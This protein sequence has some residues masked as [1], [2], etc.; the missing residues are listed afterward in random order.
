MIGMLSIL[1]ILLAGNS[2]VAGFFDYNLSLDLLRTLDI[3]TIIIIALMEVGLMI[4]STKIINIAKNKQKI[5]N[6]FIL[7]GLLFPIFMVSI[8]C[9]EMFGIGTA[10]IVLGSLT[11][12]TLSIPVMLKY[13]CK[14][15]LKQALL[16]TLLF[17]LFDGILL[18]FLGILW[19]LS[20]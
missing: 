14:L 17:L 4:V 13:K 1:M 6:Y 16:T 5:R 11:I 19:F 20:G 7:Q 15:S 3:V 8:I 12:T 2:L 10:S 9:G 18:V